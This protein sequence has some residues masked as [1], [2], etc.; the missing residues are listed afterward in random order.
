MKTIWT[1]LKN[2]KSLLLFVSILF[3]F[4]IMTG[5]LFYFKQDLSLRQE[6]VASLAGLFQNNVFTLKNIFFHLFFLVL[7]CAL[8]FCFLGL[9]LYIMY[10]FFEG[11]SLGFIIPI[12]VS[13]YKINF[14]G[15][16]F[17]YFF[18]VKFIYILLLFFFFIKAFQ[19]TKTYFQCLK[20]K[21]YVFMTNL[22]Y[23]LFLSALLL[24]NDFFIYFLGNKILIFL[25]G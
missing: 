21:T 9:P 20:N 17:A 23:I 24:L 2:H 18:L 25:L 13:L 5:F 22:K 11:I 1:S 16:F 7:L 4:G 12:F 15:Y 8:L 6:I 10:V 3:L 19:F 14:I